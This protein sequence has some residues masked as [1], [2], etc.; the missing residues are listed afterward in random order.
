M[1]IMSGNQQQAR[2]TTSPRL[3]PFPIDEA[4]CIGFMRLQDWRLDKERQVIGRRNAGA[5][6]N[7][8][9]R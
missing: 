6:Q 7:V 2:L 1:D 9:S 8:V 3:T 4:H 5:W